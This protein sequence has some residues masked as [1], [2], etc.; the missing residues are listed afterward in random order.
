MYDSY[1]SLVRQEI[2]NIPQKIREHRKLSTELQRHVTIQPLTFRVIS[3][4]FAG[5]VRPRVSCRRARSSNERFITFHSE[6]GPGREWRLQD[7]GAVGS[8]RGDFNCVQYRFL[9]NGHTRPG[10]GRLPHFI[11]RHVRSFVSVACVRVLGEEAAH[12][13]QTAHGEVTRGCNRG[14]TSG[15]YFF[16]Y[17][18]ICSY[19]NLR[20]LCLYLII[21]SCVIVRFAVFLT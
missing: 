11:S 3:R 1:I 18:M 9:P 16:K 8:R 7:G 12:E 13:L 6:T 21:N 15:T 2:R 10:K 4:H 17:L 5:N 20:G 14:I 19:Y